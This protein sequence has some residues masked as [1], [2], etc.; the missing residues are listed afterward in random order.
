MKYWIEIPQENHLVAW[1][2][3]IEESRPTG[4]IGWLDV[5]EFD[6]RR[7]E[8]L[9]PY[10][11]TSLACL[12]EEY[13]ASGARRIRMK[14]RKN[15]IV[16]KFLR[17]T[18]FDRYWDWNFDRDFCLKSGLINVLPIWQFRPERIDPFANVTQNFY[19]SHCLPGKDL[20][21][22]RLT[23]VEALNNIQ[24]HSMSKVGGFIFTQYYEK[25]KE[26]V[27][28]I[29]DF[30]TGIPTKVN[31]FLGR[32]GKEKLADNFALEKAL[33]Q[34]FSTQSTPNNRGYGLDTILSNVEAA[35]GQIE[36]LSNNA[37][38]WCRV[39][40]KK[41][42]KKSDKIKLNFKGTYLVIRLKTSKFLNLEKE[43]GEE[44][45]IF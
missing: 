15:S 23:V 26:L 10:H 25:K 44:V 11:L 40:G 36:I 6:F 32:T 12:I 45:E 20:S 21:P 13:K 17:S 27:I 8:F 39:K 42:D 14:T 33:E 34:G 19:T 5:C 35:E 18:S 43:E 2:R 24:D 29:C 16:E 4:R 1:V 28:S 7:V 30:G 31:S 41:C 9:Q 37:Y 3:F 38:Y 22:L